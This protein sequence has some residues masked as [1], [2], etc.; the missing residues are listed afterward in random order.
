MDI[1]KENILNDLKI[2]ELEFL[3][4]KDFLT[5]LKKKFGSVD[6]ETMK[7]AKL[8]KVEQ[9]SRIIE[10]FVQKFRKAVRVSRY[11]ERLLIE[12][13]KKG[14]NNVIRQKLIKVECS[15]KNIK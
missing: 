6:N 14:M 5:N 2:G 12:K 13:F 7:I 1:W 4:V 11:K 9:E 8:K 3:I 15:P 10:E